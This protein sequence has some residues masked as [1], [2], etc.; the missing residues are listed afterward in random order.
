MAELKALG[1]SYLQHC[2]V[3]ENDPLYALVFASDR[4]EADTIMKGAID[5]WRRDPKLR[6]QGWL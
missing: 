5:H 6:Q 1:Y 3:P 4:K 2:Y